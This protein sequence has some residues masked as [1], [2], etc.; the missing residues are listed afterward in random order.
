MDPFV[1]LMGPRRVKSL[2]ERAGI[3]IDVLHPPLFG[4]PGW[5]RQPEAFRRLAQW[6]VALQCPLV[7]V[8]PPRP[9]ELSKWAGDFDAGLAAWRE[10]TKGAVRLTIEN[11]AVFDHADRRHPYV[12]PQ[13]VVEFAGARGLGITLDTT[14]VASA[15]LPLVETYE[16][17]A[18]AVEHVHL[19]DIVQPHPLLDRPSL[20]TYFKH[21]QLPGAGS[22]P[23][24]PLLRKLR[25]SGYEGAVTLELSP[26]ALQVW[27]PGEPLR[28]LR[29][30]VAYVRQELA[31]G[32][33][34]VTVGEEART[35][36]SGA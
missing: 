31:S 21:H 2:S 6:A 1:A 13:R 24:R 29:R 18:W 12:R 26:V 5:N 23:L 4:L 19:S 8:H 30:S 32:T 34:A 14:H 16:A 28:R 36:M 22:L 3:P 17:V 20:D 15:G 11:L 27:H 35:A 25:E 9:D 7:V 33:G 10:V